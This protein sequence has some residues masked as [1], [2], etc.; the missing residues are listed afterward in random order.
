MT[1]QLVTHPSLPNVITDPNVAASTATKRK[2]VKGPNPLSV[3]KKNTGDSKAG[4]SQ[5][6]SQPLHAKTM[7]HPA[8]STD[9]PSDA[10]DQP[11]SRS[12]AADV[13]AQHN[14]PLKRPRESE[15]E[16]STAV[17]AGNLAVKKRKRKRPKK[18]M[19]AGSGISQADSDGE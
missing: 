15:D 1:A 16:L 19:D 2:K 5:Q 18:A 11:P 17:R 8:A 6:P 3:R 10:H 13:D 12:K 14:H 9:G 7:N 4:R